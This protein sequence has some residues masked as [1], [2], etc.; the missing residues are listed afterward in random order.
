GGELSGCILPEV[1]DT[2]RSA[3]IMMANN[4]FAYSDR[5]S[6]TAGKKYTFRADPAHVTKLNEMGVDLV[7]LANNH[8]YDWGP[9]ALMDTFDILEG[10]DVPYVGAGRNLAEA[11][12]P[13]YIKVNGRTLAYVAATQIERTPNPDTKEATEDSPGVLRTLD[14]SKFLTVIEEAEQNADFTIVYVHWGSENTDLVEASQRELAEKYVDAGADLI[15]GDHSHCLQG[16]DYVKDVPVFY[17]LGNFWFNSKTVDTC[18]VTVTVRTAKETPAMAVSRDGVENP[19]FADTLPI[20]SVQFIPCIQKSCH[21]RLAE[22]DDVSRILSYLQGICDHANVDPEGFI[23]YSEE[24]R[25]TQG[26]VNTSPSRGS[27]K[28]A[29]ANAA[30]PAIDPAA[31]PDGAGTADPAAGA[32]N[33][34]QENGGE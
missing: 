25:N 8:A 4:E 19:N 31:V 17:S 27:S 29:D 30:D 21:T 6:P 5:G 1:M 28:P 24:N 20:E 33:A 15:I 32:E 34:G 26:G 14:P 16:I 12:Q 10:A 13:V 9:D 7:A 23:T 11:M 22:G 2:M 3:D 18:I